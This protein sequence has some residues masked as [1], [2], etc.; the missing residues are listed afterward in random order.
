M[1]ATMLKGDQAVEQ[2]AAQ[3]HT[4]AKQASAA[5]VIR[6]ADLLVCDAAPRGRSMK[7]ARSGPLAPTASAVQAPMLMPPPPGL[8]TALSSTAAAFVPGGRGRAPSSE[9]G[10]DADTEAPSEEGVD[11]L[12]EKDTEASSLKDAEASS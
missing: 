12:S 11:A 7:D 3:E 8:R 1:A 2:S 9:K 4:G 10:T 6:L 5:K